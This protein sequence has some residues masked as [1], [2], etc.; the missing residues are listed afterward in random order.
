MSTCPRCQT[1]FQ[2]GAVDG[3]ADEPCWCMNLP[4]LHI[5]ACKDDKS[6]TAMPMECLCTQCLQELLASQE[7]TTAR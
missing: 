2:C 7:T 6:S 1:P 5:E 4:P 3:K